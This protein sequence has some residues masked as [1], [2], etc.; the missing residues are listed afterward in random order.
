MEKKNY[1]N[2][3]IQNETFRF[4]QLVVQGI[5]NDPVL[6]INSPRMTAEKISLFHRNVDNGDQYFRMMHQTIQE[7]LKARKGIPVVRFADG[8]YAFYRYSLK[9]N[10]LYQQ[11]ESRSAIQKAMPA[12]IEALRFLSQTGMFASLVFPGNT[13][14]EDK[15]FFSFWRRAKIDSSAITFLEFLFSQDIE[16]EQNNYLPFYVVY[17]YL[18]S[19]LFAGLVDKKNVCLIN[20]ECQMDSCRQWFARFSSHPTLTFVDIPSSY[21]ATRWAS[22]KDVV[23]TRIPAETEL[24][25]VGA[26]VGALLVCVD[27]AGRFS[28]PAIDAGHVL[29]MMNGREDKSK[30]PRMYTLWK[31][32]ENKNYE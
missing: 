1:L 20:S 16:L 10:G 29:N 12:H 11:A 17:A 27:I 19:E 8:E 26:G 4:D 21:V 9:C 2:R 31:N 18:T 23:L 28:I 13:Q 24:C 30:G 15:K 25:L 5:D 7:G 14:G 22:I 32:P 3:L 6:S